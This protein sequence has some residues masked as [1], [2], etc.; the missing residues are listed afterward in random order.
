[1]YIWD[2]GNKEYLIRERTR[3]LFYGMG[4]KVDAFFL[5]VGPTIEGFE[6]REGQ[7]DMAYEII[8]AMRLKKHIAVEAGVGI[9]KSFAYL[10]PLLIYNSAVHKPVIIATST[11]ALQEQLVKDVGKIQDL[12][13][14]SRESQDV[15]LAKGKSHYLCSKRADAYCTGKTSKMEKAIKTALEENPDIGERKDFGFAVKQSIWD[16]INIAQYDRKFCSDCDKR[17]RYD[18]IR[19]CLYT[20][21]G[22]VICNQD[23]LTAHLLNFRH[24]LQ[25]GLIN[26]DVEYVVIDEA[27]N[28][29]EKVRS[30]TTAQFSRASLIGICSA[31]FKAL[32]SEAHVYVQKFFDNTKDAVTDFFENL[33]K[34]V[35]R[36]IEESTQNMK[37]ADR[38][39]FE[40]NTKTTKLLS[41]MINT[42]SA[43]NDKVDLY[44][45]LA[46]RDS[47]RKTN[48]A[49][50]LDSISERLSKMLDNAS[51]QVF[52]LEKRGNTIDF[53]F[54]PKDMSGIISNLFFGYDFTT[55]LTSATLTT[56]GGENLRAQYAYFLRNT[57]F[58][59]KTGI[60]SE[61][62][63]SPFPY[64]E[65]AMIYYCNDL[66]HPTRE[67]DDFI[68]QGTDR[69]IQILE[70]SHGK[71]LVLF[72][73]KTDME[74]VYVQLKEREF[75]YKILVQAQGASQESVLQQFR[76][77]TDSVLLGT[78][79]YWEGIDI[80]GKSLSNL[81]IF[82]LPFP[83][84]DPIIKDKVSAA[85]DPL[86]EVSVPEMIIKLKQGI[87]RLIRSEKDTGIVSI[88]DPRLRDE[89][90]SPYRDTT[91]AALPIQNRTNDINELADFYK[92]I[93]P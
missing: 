69:L 24:G 6:N 11:I 80:Q 35:A 62:K 15:T 17:C 5:D 75:P 32:P 55:I 3:K 64:D 16:S 76:D 57:G 4:E 65:H 61:P 70:I 72:T 44:S 68:K 27:H 7:V 90:P 25:K 20:T 88:I 12:L 51:N 86:M 78:G 19:T 34:Q 36:Q 49:D 91:W 37:Y 9:G 1:M 85:K 58:S 42:L 54:C 67:H 39:F 56:G 46:R 33:K 2:Y 52:W 41:V 13:G 18:R 23:F 21:E 77:D 71:A 38:F 89:S 45:G 28:L 79:A 59:T 43:F 82:R 26:H 50:E 22:I 66:P 8:D 47:K 40:K 73:A 60:L 87:G 84:P 92:I 48:A 63:P 29:E 30:A 31:A 10:I 93:N 53:C 83:V 81:V 14:I 74:E